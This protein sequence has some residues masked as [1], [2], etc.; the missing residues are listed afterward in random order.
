MVVW[1]KGPM[2]MGWHYRRSYEVVLVGQKGAGKWRGGNT[3]EN[4]I[5]PGMYGIQKNIPTASEHPTAKPVALPAAF[6]GWHTDEG[7]TVLDPFAG[8]GPTGRAA[9]DLG[10]KAILIEVEERYCEIAAR[11][12]GQEVFP[13]GASESRDE[14]CVYANEREA[15]ECAAQHLWHDEG[16]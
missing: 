10:R 6:I 1:D 11:R 12:M 9:K 8:A 15:D 7:D 2:G 14:K 5:R 16:E 13:F 3:V 4:I